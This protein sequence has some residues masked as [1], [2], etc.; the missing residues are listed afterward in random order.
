MLFRSLFFVSASPSLSLSLI[1]FVFLYIIFILHLSLPLSISLISSQYTLIYTC[2]PSL[3]SLC[4]HTLINRLMISS[5]RIL[6]NTLSTINWEEHLEH[7]RCYLF[8]S[9]LFIFPFYLF[10]PSLPFFSFFLPFVFG[11]AIA[12]HYNNSI[13]SYFI[14][15]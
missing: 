14:I 1:F 3:Y 7:S 11:D 2:A 6:S 4:L 5:T 8:L 15:L 13:Y 9:L 12:I 10:Y